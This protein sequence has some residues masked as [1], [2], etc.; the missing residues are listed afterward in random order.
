M[1]T[2][3]WKAWCLATWLCFSVALADVETLKIYLDADRS[4]HYRSARSI[5]MGVHTALDKVNYQLGPVKV[6]VETLDHRG[7]SARSLKNMKAVLEDPKGLLLVGGLHSPPL[8]VYRDWINQSKLLTLVPWAAGG[9]ITR[10]SGDKNWIFRL[11]IDDTKAGAKLISHAVEERKFKQVALFLESTPWGEGNHR[12][13]LATTQEKGLPEPSVHWFNWS[14]KE[15]G[16]RIKLRRIIEEG[17]EVIIL[18]ANAIE[19]EKICR[20]MASME[21]RIPI[22]SHWGVTGGDFPE[23][24]GPEIRRDIDLSFLQTNF[25]FQDQPRAPKVDRVLERAR[26]LFPDEVSLRDGVRAPA[27]FVHA[28]DLMGLLIEAARDC[29]WNGSK[30]AFRESLRVRLEQLQNPIPGLIKTYVRP[31]V[32]FAPGASDA[33]EALGLEDLILCR[34]DEQGRIFRVSATA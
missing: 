1:K 13:I 4:R 34:F 10:H 15:N 30:E 20:A 11:S 25:S 24:L 21:K 3:C 5:E 26:R 28:Y 14:I 29:P 9:P 18:V 31:F 33:H 6:E 23:R 8:I 19:S 12:N 17:A 7:N 27:G 16:A 2:R 32:S 22:I